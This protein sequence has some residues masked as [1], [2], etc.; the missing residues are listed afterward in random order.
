MWFALAVLVLTP[1]A[2]ALAGTPGAPAL[3]SWLADA[4]PALA[5]P[6]AV[7]SPALLASVAV[8]TLLGLG[9]ARGATTHLS[10]VAHEFGHGITAAALGGRI[11]RLRMHRDGSGIA[12]TSL[13]AGRPA[14]AFAV[15]AAG[16]LAPGVLA[17]ASMQATT[18]ARLWI[19]YLV[20]VVGVMLVLAVRSWWGALLALGLGAGGWAV[21][22]L[23][24]PTFAALAVAGLAGVLGGGGV[25]DAVAQWRG[26]STTPR[27]D[28][29]AMARQT[30]LPTG[31]FAG[32]HLLAGVALATA[33]L[34]QPLW[35]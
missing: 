22:V 24:P 20:A 31:L 9:R 5:E 2:W 25:A 34:T 8:G 23:A 14:R 17:L 7:E 12:L 4:A 16:Y 6:A 33:S 1:L 29:R 3:A 27:S 26:R 28:A 19:T 32:V 35:G 18:L 15:S 11:T 13:P 10:T 21:V 30:G